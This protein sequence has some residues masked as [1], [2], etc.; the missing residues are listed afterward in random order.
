M[1]PDCFLMRSFMKNIFWDIQPFIK[2]GSS[3]LQPDEKGFCTV[4]F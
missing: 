1:S 2:G 3:Q 4:L